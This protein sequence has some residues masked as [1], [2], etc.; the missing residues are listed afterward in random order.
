MILHMLGG[1]PAQLSAIKRAK[2]LGYR[3]VVSDLNPDA[4]GFEICDFK[5]FASTFDEEAVLADAI[6]FKS[7]FIMTTGTDQPVLTA[8]NVSK[9]LDLPY[10]LTPEQALVVT[11][12]KVMKQK[13]KLTG[14]PSMPF[15]IIGKN[16]RDEDL[17]D[18]I[19]PLVIKPLDS[20]GQRG[21]I[22]VNSIK[23]IRNNFDLLLSFSKELEI[24][25]EEYYPSNELTISGW[26]NNGEATVLTITDRVTI[27]NGPHLGVC[28]SHRYPSLNQNK[29]DELK[30]LTSKV[31]QMIGLK[32]GPIY[33]QI[34][35]GSKGFV[36]NEIACRLGGAYEDEFI[37][38]MTGEK[39]LENMIE[40]TAGSVYNPLKQQIVDQNI[41]GKFF[42]L[43]MFFTTQGI[44]H[45]MEGM[46]K[47][48]ES[49][50]ILNGRFLL[51]NDTLIK[52]R[53]NSTQRAGYFIVTGRSPIEINNSIKKM[54]QYIKLED[55][56]GN[57][58]L[59]FYPRMLF[60]L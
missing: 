23:E 11:N 14:I 15:T 54:Y 57:S 19:F 45:K 29:E 16:F 25:A 58:M 30:E 50:D 55:K 24:L 34:L 21:V 42:S 56:A 52:S 4:P 2:E 43:Q 6:K 10:F 46:E 17:K 49:E 8:A 40:M 51:Q 32:N 20:Q 44:L 53:E 47:V 26:V 12:K 48:I 35:N 37:P 18:L 33:F 1:G 3:V 28:I 9:R 22:K 41:K 27:D 5:S 36:I 7:N 38:I 31:T 59:Q 13:L 60:P 39:L